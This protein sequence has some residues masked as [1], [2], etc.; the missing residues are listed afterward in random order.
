[1]ARQLLNHSQVRARVEEIAHKGPPEVVRRDRRDTGA[2][3]QTDQPVVDRLFSEPTH[4][5]RAMPAYRNEERP[6]LAPSK[7]Q[8]VSD[9]LPRPVVD[10]DFAFAA[11]LPTHEEPPGPGIVVGNIEGDRFV[12][13]E[14]GRIDEGDERSVP[15][16]DRLAL[17][18]DL[19]EERPHLPRRDRPTLRHR[20]AA[21]HRDAD[22]LVVRVP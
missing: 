21:D 17:P 16:T 20:R 18:A 5:E 22:R 3:S 15:R 10:P 1:M 4:A 19:A 9:R 6:G 13:A 8:P 2:G 14:A 12:S 7:H 11:P